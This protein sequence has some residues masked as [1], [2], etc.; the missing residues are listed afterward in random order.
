MVIK[1]NVL[2]QSFH[3]QQYYSGKDGSIAKD[4][5]VHK[6]KWGK[7][8]IRTRFHTFFQLCL[9]KHEGVSGNQQRKS[10]RTRLFLLY[11]TL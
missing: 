2:D 5:S 4:V 8:V 9:K 6:F 10:T 7:F 11:H 1:I 3:V